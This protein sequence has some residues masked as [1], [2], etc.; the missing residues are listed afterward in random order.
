VNNA[1][2]K[3]AT[4]N[5]GHNWSLKEGAIPLCP[6]LHCNQVDKEKTPMSA[7]AS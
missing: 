7:V 4:G 5:R 3:A 2:N 6:E 1:Q